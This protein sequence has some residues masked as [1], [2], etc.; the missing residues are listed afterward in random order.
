MHPAIFSLHPGHTLSSPHLFIPVSSWLPLLVS[1]S[2]HLPPFRAEL[3]RLFAGTGTVFAGMLQGA[4]LS[5][6]YASADLFVTPSE[7]ET[8]GNVVLESMA[9]GVPVVAARAGGIPDIIDREGEN[10]F[11]FEPGNVADAV[12]KIKPL[13]ASKGLRR[14]TAET[15]RKE[16]E[17]LTWKAASRHVRDVGYGTTVFF[18]RKKQEKR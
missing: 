15:A 2:H 11:L 9:S 18:A 14:R 7:S 3:E 10:G 13:I 4:E 16:A 5:A 1:L 12:A 17:G 6:A 8:L